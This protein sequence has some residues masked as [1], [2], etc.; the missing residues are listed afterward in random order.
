VMVGGLVELIW[1]ANQGTVNHPRT[2]RLGP[3]AHVWAYAGSGFLLGLIV[4]LAIGWFLLPTILGLLG[5][6]VIGLFTRPT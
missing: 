3:T 5:G 4:D 2:N 6:L 1:F